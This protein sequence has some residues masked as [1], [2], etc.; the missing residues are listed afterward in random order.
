MG[1]APGSA[2]VKQAW[3][4]RFLSW[5]PAS[6]SPYLARVQHSAL[7]LLPLIKSSSSPSPTFLSFKDHLT[8]HRKT[9][10]SHTLTLHTHPRPGLP[11]ALQRTENKA[12]SLLDPHEW[13]KLSL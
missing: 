9:A 10:P 2:C 6:L 12:P 5:I 11:Q 4:P 8:G 3:N 13:M 7:P 1:P